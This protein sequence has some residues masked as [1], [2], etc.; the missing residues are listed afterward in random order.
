[1]DYET[2]K[3]T[4]DRLS[5]EFQGSIKTRQMQV[6]NLRREF[7]LIR[8]IE[9]EAV[10]DFVDGLMKVV[11]QIRLLGESMLDGRVVEKVLLVNS[12]QAIELR[13]ENRI[14]QAIEMA[15]VAN[16]KARH[17][18]S[19][20]RLGDGKLV[21]VQDKGNIEVSTLSDDYDVH[22]FDKKCE[23]RMAKDLIVVIKMVNRSFPMNWGEVLANA[24]VVKLDESEL[25]HRRLEHCNYQ[26]QS[27]LLRKEL[28]K[29]MPKIKEND[30]IF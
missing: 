3:G 12:L 6:L 23:I 5:K 13:K 24:I 27:N 22:F 14:S 28:V 30:G 8:M 10:K 25:W 16:S 7:E 21:S 17:I 20:V 19:R 2:T 1:M 11:N 26:S 29:G 15:L 9:V 4:W 18:C